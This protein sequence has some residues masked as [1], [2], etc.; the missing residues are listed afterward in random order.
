MT[1]SDILKSVSNQD[2]D[3]LTTW[4]LMV[5]VFLLIPPLCSLEIVRSD[6]FKDPSWCV[7]MCHC[8]YSYCSCFEAGQ[9]TVQSLMRLGPS[10]DKLASAGSWDSCENIRQLRCMIKYD[11]MIKMMRVLYGIIWY[12]SVVTLTLNRLWEIKIVASPK[13][14]LCRT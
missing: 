9:G 7:M 14:K 13:S 11:E 3:T 5:L 12:Y 10:K 6:G 2:F 8:L 1:F 4:F